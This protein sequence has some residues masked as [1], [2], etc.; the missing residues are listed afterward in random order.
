MTPPH[1][2][3][4]PHV[5]PKDAPLFFTWHL[6]GSVPVSL[7]PPR[8]AAPRAGVSAAA[9][10]CAG[11]GQIHPQ[12][13]SSRTPP[14]GRVCGDVKSRSSPDSAGDR[15]QSLVEIGRMRPPVRLT[16]CQD[17]QASLFGKENFTIIGCGMRASSAGSGLTSK[18]IR[19]RPVWSETPGT[20]PG[21]AQA[22]RRVSTRYAKVRAP[23]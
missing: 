22:S 15:P 2:R 5:Y 13:R 4:L 20:F 19:S 9:R 21:P 6:H 11:S 7:L 12:G 16:V 1:R 17:G 18:I 3:R 23:R 14:A 8:H 10:D